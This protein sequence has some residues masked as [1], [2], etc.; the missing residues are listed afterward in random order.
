[1]LI[2]LLFIFVCMGLF[3][4]QSFGFIHNAI[5]W[6]YIQY[7]RLGLYTMQS[8]VLS[9][10]IAFYNET[11]NGI[12]HYFSMFAVFFSICSIFHLP[13]QLYID[14]IVCIYIYIQ[15]YAYVSI[16]LYSIQLYA[17]IYIYTIIYSI[18]SYT[19]I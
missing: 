2:I 1:M 18:E 15:L 14:S 7:N 8:S 3:T 4:I 6:V 10:N 9:S 5:I 11:S 17:Y 16:H 19:Y 12:L 13:H